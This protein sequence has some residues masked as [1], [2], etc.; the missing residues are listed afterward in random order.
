MGFN[1]GFKGLNFW[2]GRDSGVTYFRVEIL[3][4]NWGWENLQV[5]L[6]VKYGNDKST[7]GF[8]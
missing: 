1:S 2:G 7:S 6:S 4:I 5:E 8:C 3:R